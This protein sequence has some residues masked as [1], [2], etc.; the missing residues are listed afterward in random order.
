M[1]KVLIAIDD[2]PIAQKIA[3]TGYALAQAMGAQT[4]LLHV[5]SDVPFYSS[6]KYSPVI[7]FEGFNK[8]IESVTWQQLEEVA[9]NFLDNLKEILGDQN[10]ETLVKQGDFGNTILETAKE[11]GAD[12][13][14][15]GTHGR[16]GL[17]KILVGS[18]AEKVLQRTLI[19]LF[20]VPAKYH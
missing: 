14:V 1:K 9:G 20:I 17:E 11:E 5:V 10:I 13:I 7:G 8:A 18:V 4:I 19:P 3:K 2:S 12:M 15:M 16:R 6:F